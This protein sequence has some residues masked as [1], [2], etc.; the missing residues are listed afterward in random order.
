MAVE[1]PPTIFGLT[2]PTII[3]KIMFR[4]ASVIKIVKSRL[5]GWIAT[6]VWPDF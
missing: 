2:R 5:F 4:F 3:I 6:L 1:I